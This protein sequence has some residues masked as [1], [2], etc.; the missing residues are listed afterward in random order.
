M[1]TALDRVQVLLQPE[2]YAEL[3][4][5]AKGDRRSLAAMA[6]VLITEGISQ[7][8]R[9]GRFR[10]DPDS[11]VYTHARARQAARQLGRPVAEAEDI[12]KA[13][14]GLDIESIAAKTG[15]ELVSQKNNKGSRPSPKDISPEEKKAAVETLSV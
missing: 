13:A 11:P 6:A 10:P 14:K 9:D 1:P 12:E 8:I 4:L 15:A 3:S 5:I 7:R 2:E